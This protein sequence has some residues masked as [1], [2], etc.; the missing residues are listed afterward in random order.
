MAVGGTTGCSPVAV[1]LRDGPPESDY[2]ALRPG[3]HTP[4]QVDPTEPSPMHFDE[5]KQQLP[6]LDEQSLNRRIG[7]SGNALQ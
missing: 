4:R 3:R 6:D 2:A 1:R 7:V 5:F